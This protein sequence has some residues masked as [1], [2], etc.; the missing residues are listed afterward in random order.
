MGIHA[1]AIALQ[2][3][4]KWVSKVGLGWLDIIELFQIDI[5]F[6]FFGTESPH[7]MVAFPQLTTGRRKAFFHVGD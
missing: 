7:E 5:E 3:L 1:G 4:G 2:T 6:F